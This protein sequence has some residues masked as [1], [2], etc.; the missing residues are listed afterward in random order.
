MEKKTI[1]VRVMKEG[2]SE[3]LFDRYLNEVR[4]KAMGK[5]LKE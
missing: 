3:M 4:E 1:S 2:F 5:L